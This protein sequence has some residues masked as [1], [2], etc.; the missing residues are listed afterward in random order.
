MSEQEQQIVWEAT[1]DDRYRCVVTRTGERTGYYTIT[2]TESGEELFAEEV[3]LAY[4]ALFGPDVGDV[5]TWQERA[6]EVVEGREGEE[7]DEGEG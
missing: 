7:R 1:L 6:I 5:R 2:D 4:R 3:G